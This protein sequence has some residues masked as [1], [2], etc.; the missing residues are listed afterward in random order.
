MGQRGEV[1]V[2]QLVRERYGDDAVL[3]GFTTYHGTVTAASA[4]GG[5]AERKRVRPALA[6]SYEVLFHAA[7]PSRFLLT[8]REGDTV[9]EGLRIP[10]LE[11]AIGV[12]YRPESE[13]LSHYFRVRL[14]DQFDAVLHFD[15]TRAVEPLERIATFPF[16]V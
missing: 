13:R 9:L 12:I 14:L 1:N 11:R 4:W 3:V 5:P 8:W 15:E 7:Q 16:A 10:R 6:D 2:G